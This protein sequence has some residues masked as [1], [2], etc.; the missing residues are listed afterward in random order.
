MQKKPF[1]FPKNILTHI[2]EM[3]T[4]ALFGVRLYLL[5]KCDSENNS[6]LK[7]VVFKHLCA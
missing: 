5:G 2:L 6:F 1:F 3:L 4:L 7:P